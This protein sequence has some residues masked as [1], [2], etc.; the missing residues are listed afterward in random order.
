MGVD[1]AVPLDEKVAVL[2]H[3]YDLRG[4]AR[5]EHVGDSIRQRPFGM[6]EDHASDGI[7][8]ERV[9][10]LFFIEVLVIYGDLDFA[11]FLREFAF[12]ERQ[13]PGSVFHG[14]REYHAVEH[15]LV[16]HRLALIGRSPRLADLAPVGWD[17]AM[18][19]VMRPCR[20]ERGGDTDYLA[21]F[22]KGDVD[23]GFPEVIGR[24]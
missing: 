8:T 7:R 9:R 12:E 1:D 14:L 2:Y 16:D 23:E 24:G 4:M 20:I 18:W 6:H 22:V 19:T 17:D 5:F 21:L 15:V 13:S 3:F 10:V 11:P